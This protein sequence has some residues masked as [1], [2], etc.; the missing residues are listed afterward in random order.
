MILYKLELK[1][2]CL[3]MVEAIF[4]CSPRLHTFNHK[5]SKNC[6]IM[7]SLF[8]SQITHYTP[9]HLC[10]KTI[11]IERRFTPIAYEWEKLQRAIWQNISHLLSKRA[12]C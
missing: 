11:Y 9:M 2:V 5:Y 3:N 4:F 6:I 10:T 7:K 12:N 1:M 8:V